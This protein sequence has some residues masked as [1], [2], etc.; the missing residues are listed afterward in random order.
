MIKPRCPDNCEKR[1][2]GCQG[3]CEVYKAYRAAL[4]EQNKMIREAKE[5][6]RGWTEAS[7]KAIKRSKE[8]KRKLARGVVHR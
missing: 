2:P 4:D 7:A 5:N 6:G 3:S 8:F 1:V